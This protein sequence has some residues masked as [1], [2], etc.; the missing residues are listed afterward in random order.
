M[1]C[2]C[3]GSIPDFSKCTDLKE[4]WLGANTLEGECILMSTHQFSH[5]LRPRS[6]TD[7]AGWAR[8]EDN[9]P[10]LCEVNVQVQEDEDSDDDDEDS[11]DEDEDY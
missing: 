6:C 11:D 8:N 4:M 9:Y 7:P 10:R 2:D 1:K 5:L 3:A